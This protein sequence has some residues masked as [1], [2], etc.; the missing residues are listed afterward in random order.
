MRG[1][2]EEHFRNLPEVAGQLNGKVVKLTGLFDL[3][4]TPDAPSMRGIYTP[5]DGSMND[6]GLSSAWVVVRMEFS[7]EDKAYIQDAFQGMHY[8]TVVGQ[9]DEGVTEESRSSEGLKD[10]EAFTYESKIYSYTM[11]EACF[12]TDTFEYTGTL[13]K[14]S[15]GSY[16]LAYPDGKIRR[17]VQFREG[18]AIPPEGT[19]VT[20]RSKFVEMGG[21]NHL[22]A[23]IVK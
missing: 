11:S 16:V 20:I 3:D 1:L 5:E 10:G 8:V 18:E 6:A 23:V 14:G 7:E 19:E 13:E 21:V 15:D 17:G 4:S 12:V 9:I 22:D 2:A